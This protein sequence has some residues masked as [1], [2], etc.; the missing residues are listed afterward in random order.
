ML[1]IFHILGFLD[2]PLFGV[3]RKGSYCLCFL[4]GAHSGDGYT[5]RA[6]AIKTVKIHVSCFRLGSTRTAP[7]RCCYTQSG[8]EPLTRPRIIEDVATYRRP[9][10]WWWPVLGAMGIQPLLNWIESSNIYI[11]IYI[12]II[13]KY[14]Y[15]YINN[16]KINIYKISLYREI[17]KM[18][19][20]FYI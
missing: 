6:G 17:N 2:F 11:Y 18:Y 16:K 5:T 14:I 19:F 13:N 4:F 9:K 15:I 12:Q 10:A 3:T 20:S 1:W 8:E 7:L